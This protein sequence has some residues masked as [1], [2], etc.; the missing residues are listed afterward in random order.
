MHILQYF[1]RIF[2]VRRICRR[3]APPPVC[4]VLRSGPT[5][6]SGAA[7]QKQISSSRVA[8]WVE[9]AKGADADGTG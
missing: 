8:Q 7:R 1:V 3:S 6:V 9:R 2:R 5:S 4:P